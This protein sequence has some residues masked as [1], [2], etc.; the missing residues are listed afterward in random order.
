MY[1]LSGN[2]SKLDQLAGATAVVTGT[3]DGK[4]ISVRSIADEEKRHSVR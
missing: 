4:K 3:I 2:A 1:W